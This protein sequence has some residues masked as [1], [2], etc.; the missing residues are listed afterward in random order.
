MWDVTT[1]PRLC[2]SSGFV[3]QAGLSGLVDAVLV[4]PLRGS[5]LS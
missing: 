5:Y 3:T 1:E 2:Y 4:L